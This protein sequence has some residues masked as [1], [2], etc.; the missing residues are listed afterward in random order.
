[1]EKIIGKSIY[2]IVS[3]ANEINYF[4]ISINLNVSK[5]QKNTSAETDISNLYR[6]YI[7]KV[8][9][10]EIFPQREYNSHQI[11]IDF[12]EKTD[13]KLKKEDEDYL[14]SLLKGRLSKW[15]VPHVLNV[16]D[17]FSKEMMIQL[18]KTAINTRDPSYNNS[19]LTPATRVFDL[20]VNEY[21]LA[22]F[23]NS[24]YKDKMGILR[25]FYWVRSSLITTIHPDDTEE[26]YKMNFI[27]KGTAFKYD[28]EANPEIYNEYKTQVNQ[29][30]NERI[31]LLL[32]EY[33]N[34]NHS[35]LR[36][37]ISWYLPKKIEEYPQYLKH[38]AE[39]YL[40][41]NK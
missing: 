12:R 2:R 7:E 21:L 18:I 9:R 31:E 28:K 3:L 13:G 5:F 14:I 29:K 4:L 25:T 15:F 26:N 36:E 39:R 30:N 38:K 34:S 17:S 10:K 11:F 37:S 16:M 33:L 23:P 6:L 1:M 19:F 27:W 20:E 35:N 22:L 8:R 32:N 24:S 41:E 40:Q